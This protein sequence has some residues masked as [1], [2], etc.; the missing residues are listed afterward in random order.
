MQLRVFP[1]GRT[2]VGAVVVWSCMKLSLCNLHYVKAGAGIF[3]SVERNL[4]K[5]TG[6][7]NLSLFLCHRDTLSL[8][9]SSLPM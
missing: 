7:W 3:T 9:P 6:V 2:G 8:E 1:G 5:L 4:N